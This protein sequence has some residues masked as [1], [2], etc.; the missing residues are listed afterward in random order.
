MDWFLWH[1]TIDFHCNIYVTLPLIYVSNRD[2]HLHD[3]V[4]G[5]LLVTPAH[6]LVLV[7][8]LHLLHG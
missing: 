1:G 8:G 2:S 4:P 6:R 7:E 3:P 5:G